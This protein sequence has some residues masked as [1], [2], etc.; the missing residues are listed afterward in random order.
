MALSY[1]DK[2]AYAFNQAKL[3]A[4]N[5]LRGF[6]SLHS[7]ACSTYKV[8]HSIAGNSVNRIMPVCPVPCEKVSHPTRLWAE[9]VPCTGL[10]TLCQLTWEAV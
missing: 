9:G 8:K 1:L 5:Q 10:L 3:L 4:Q 6:A 2:A 7:S